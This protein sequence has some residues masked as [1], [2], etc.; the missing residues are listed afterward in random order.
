MMQK[1]NYCDGEYKVISTGLDIHW[2][3]QIEYDWLSNV[4]FEA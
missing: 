1:I 2:H 4:L 3:T